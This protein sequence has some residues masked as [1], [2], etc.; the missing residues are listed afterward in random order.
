[1]VNGYHIPEILMG[2]GDWTTTAAIIVLTQLA[3]FEDDPKTSQNISGLFD[4]LLKNTPHDAYSTYLHALVSCW[5][6]IPGM[7]ADTVKKLDKIKNIVESKP[8]MDK[9]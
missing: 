4:V 3:C 8:D 1:M 5:T 7:P 2:P 9:K 6:F